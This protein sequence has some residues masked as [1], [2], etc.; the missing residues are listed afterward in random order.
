MQIFMDSANVKMIRDAVTHG[1][2]DGVTTNPSLIA[3]EGADFRQV[4]E[5]ICRAVPGPVSVEV[6]GKAYDEMIAEG[7]EVAKIADNVVVKIPMLKEGLRAVRELTRDG[8]RVNVTLVFSAAQG[9]LA[10]KA[11]ATYVSP[12]VGRLD[13]HA[14]VGME[15]VRDLVTI[16]DNY[17][18]PTQVL[19]ASIRHPGHVVEAALAGAHVVTVPPAVLEQLLKHPL[20]DIGLERFLADWQKVPRGIFGP[21]R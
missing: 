20:T 7:R 18:L 19:A 13:D 12:F 4:I 11:G 2:I 6:V 8:I 15:V 14:H 17:G 9:L 3:K 16:Y 5:E 10:A 21:P 1:L